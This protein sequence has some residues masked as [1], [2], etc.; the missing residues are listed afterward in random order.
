MAFRGLQNESKEQGKAHE[1]VAKDL[2]TRV[3]DPFQQ[4]AK[5]HE[6][7]SRSIVSEMSILTFPIGQV[8][9]NQEHRSGRLA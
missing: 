2:H 7:R 8:K 5:A 4:W 3:A 1:D 6:V 9:E